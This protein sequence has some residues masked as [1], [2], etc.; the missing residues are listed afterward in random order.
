ML[1]LFVCL[2]LML[3]VVVGVVFDLVACRYR[4]VLDAVFSKMSCPTEQC[5]SVALVFAHCL[6]PQVCCGGLCRVG[7]P[8]ARTKGVCLFIL[9]T[10]ERLVQHAPH[11]YAP[12]L[13]IVRGQM[14]VCLM[15]YFEER[16]C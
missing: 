9:G 15:F 14:L 4:C 7:V 1:T 12:K 13:L 16:T 5:V 10:N 11:H 8:T 6:I 2:V 3:C